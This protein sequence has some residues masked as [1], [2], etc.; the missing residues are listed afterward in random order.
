MTTKVLPGASAATRGLQ[1][2]ALAG[3]VLVAIQISLGTWLDSA[4]LPA[5]DHGA[6]WAAGFAEAFSAGPAELAGHAVVGVALFANAIS[7][8]IRARRAR[9]LDL[10]VLG[11]VAVIAVG[12]AGVAGSAFVGNQRSAAA[13]TMGVA[14]SVDLICIA[15]YLLRSARPQPTAPTR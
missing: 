9:R 2:A 5:G 6:D 4:S 1:P 3:L 10:A 7:L 12:V 13:I 8:V 15:L 14:T 11:A